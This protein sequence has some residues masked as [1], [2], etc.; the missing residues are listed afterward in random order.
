MQADGERMDR[1]SGV[2]TDSYVSCVMRL[3]MA[4]HDLYASKKSLLQAQCEG[5][6]VKGLP[7]TGRPAGWFPATCVQIAVPAIPSSCRSTN[8]RMSLTAN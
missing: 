8:E 5:Y 6:L 2:E 1:R 4:A 3:L 7:L